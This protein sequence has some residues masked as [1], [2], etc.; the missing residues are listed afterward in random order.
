M[1]CK[2]DVMLSEDHRFMQQQK[3]EDYP[4]VNSDD[5]PLLKF[6]I[7]LPP[8]YLTGLTHTSSPHASYRLGRIDFRFIMRVSRVLL[9]VE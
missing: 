6:V 9:L 3:P 1:I 2:I 5:Q 7:S 8:E 4:K